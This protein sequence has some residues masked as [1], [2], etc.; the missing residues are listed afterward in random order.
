MT[1]PESS[2]TRLNRLKR[3][4][5]RG[6]YDQATIYQIIDEALYCHIGF[7]QGNQPFVIPTIHARLENTL[8]FHG[9]KAS[10]LLKHIQTGS[11]IC[12]AITLLD[13]IVFARSVFN[14]SMNY[15][16]V[17]LFGTG[18]LID[19]NPEKLQALQAIMEHVAQ[20]RWE[21]ARKP[22]LKE[23]DSTSVVAMPIENASAKI[24]S[25]PPVDDEDDYALPVWA[26]NLPLPQLALSPVSDPKADANLPIPD[27]IRYYNRTP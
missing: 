27:Y 26:G 17:V 18:R 21:D 14:H 8:L 6:H 23:L 13:E 7:T 10:R 20:G 5:E 24:R 2:N 15:R 3:H 22:T 4:P 9:A 16:S 25:G 12:V 1:M 11:P 19:T